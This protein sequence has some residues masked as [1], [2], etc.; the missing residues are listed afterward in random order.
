MDLLSFLHLENVSSKTSHGFYNFHIQFENKQQVSEVFPVAG[1]G[2]CPPRH[3][4]SAARGNATLSLRYAWLMKRDTRIICIAN[5]TLHIT[6]VMIKN[7]PVLHWKDELTTFI[8]IKK[9]MYEG[10]RLLFFLTAPL[11]PGMYSSSVVK[12]ATVL[13]SLSSC[14]IYCFQKTKILSDIKKS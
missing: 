5:H 3:L 9:S 11:S 13:F 1:R 10:W 7:K 4:P 6:F 12:Q 2:T 8:D 14:I